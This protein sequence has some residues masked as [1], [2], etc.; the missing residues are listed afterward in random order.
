MENWS[1]TIVFAVGYS[2]HLERIARTAVARPQP[3][4]TARGPTPRAILALALIALAAWISPRQLAA[5]GDSAVPQGH[6]Q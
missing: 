6:W 4:T 2:A 5:P 1:P 3:D